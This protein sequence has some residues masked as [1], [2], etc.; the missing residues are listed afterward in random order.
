MARNSAASPARPDGPSW[1]PSRHRRAAVR[2]RP[3]ILGAVLPFLLAGCAAAPMA[4]SAAS[5]AVELAGHVASS[6]SS[7]NTPVPA[8]TPDAELR[9]ARASRAAGDYL[10]A[11]NLYKSVLVNRPSD[12]AVRVELGDTMLQMGAIDDAITV[13]QKVDAK[14]PEALG[15]QIGMGRVELSLHH[16]EKA[17]AHFDA[18][19]TMSQGNVKALIGRGVALDFMKRHAEAQASYREVLAKE[20]RHVA[21][22]VD[23]ALSLA[24]SGDKAQALDI[25]TP[26]GRS[27][28]T[29]ARIRQDLALVYGM[30]GDLKRAEQI[31]RLDLSESDTETNLRF[32]SYLHDENK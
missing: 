15:A 21:A 31:S 3:L 23:L 6:A 22:R 17:I 5:S 16:P 9:L 28:L 27:P 4:I 11:M 26:I 19:L 18:A 1:K 13:Y 8:S 12:D 29:S 2:I 14:G 25:L 24:L 20:P 32:F 10:S 7:S 30:Q